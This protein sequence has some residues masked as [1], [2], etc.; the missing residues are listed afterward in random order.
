MKTTTVLGL[1]ASSPISL[2][3]PV[4]KASVARSSRKFVEQPN[5]AAASYALDFVLQL[6]HAFSI[7]QRIKNPKLRIKMSVTMSWLGR[8][9]SW[10][11][12]EWPNNEHWD[13]N[14]C[15]T[16]PGSQ[17]LLILLCQH[18]YILK[19]RRKMQRL[20]GR[21]CEGWLKRCTSAVPNFSKPSTLS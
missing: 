5:P 17:A 18:L 1:R 9:A 15:S 8:K 4:V 14:Y 20:R 2:R 19:A 7:P 11:V 10:I 3:W 16:F 6:S 21:F 12:T 13:D